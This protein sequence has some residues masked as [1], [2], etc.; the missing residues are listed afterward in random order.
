MKKSLIAALSLSLLAPF[1]FAETKKA[2]PAADATAPADPKPAKKDP[3]MTKAADAKPEAKKETKPEPKPAAAKTEPKPEPKKE[4]PKVV[5]KPVKKTADKPEELSESD[6][7]LL[8]SAKKMSATLT[9]AQRTKLM[10]LVNKGDTKAIQE[11]D[12]VGEGKAGNIIKDR[13]YT[14]AEDIIMVDGIGESTFE[15][16][17]K[18]AKGEQP[19]DDAKPAEKKPAPVAG[20]KPADAKPKK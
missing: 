17:I 7:E 8:A 11:I 15:K 13:P 2:D 18:F 16:I 5:K 14:N 20:K 12:G 6:K 3:K 19:K 4:A 1:A 10:D 9:P